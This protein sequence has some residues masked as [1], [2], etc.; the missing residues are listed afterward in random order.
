MK[1][2]AS[3][4]MYKVNGTFNNKVFST[5]P[6]VPKFHCTFGEPTMNQ[7]EDMEMDARASQGGVSKQS[8]K[9]MGRVD[10]FEIDETM[11]EVYVKD[12]FGIYI[13]YDCVLQD[14]KGVEDELVKICSYYINRAE[15]LQDVHTEKPAPAKDRLECLSD[16]L[17]YE[18]SFHFK[19]VKLCMA[20]L[21]CYEHIVDPLEQQRLMQIITD[22]MARRP[23]LNLQANYFRD[24]YAAESECL[25]N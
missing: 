18:A 1:N 9:L 21:E 19:K 13:L 8:L 6:S 25:D 20:H 22:L 15:V 17:E 24:S 3:V 2:M 14:M 23:R 16:L 10:H 12:D 4:R 11:E 7:T 5:C